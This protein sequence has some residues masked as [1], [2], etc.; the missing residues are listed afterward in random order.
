MQLANLKN[1][2]IHVVP[3]TKVYWTKSRKSG[4]LDM[5]GTVSRFDDQRV[6]TIAKNQKV[7]AFIENN[8]FY[9][10]P[11]TKKKEET[12]IKS[13]FRKDEFYCPFSH[14]DVPRKE[15]E[16]WRKLLREVQEAR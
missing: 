9:V 4:A 11:Y 12:L 10:T 5:T 6:Y 3:G 1:Q 8:E 14:D 16:L 13:H 2:S 15:I 7:I